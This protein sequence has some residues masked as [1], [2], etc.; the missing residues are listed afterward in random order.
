MEETRTA[1]VDFLESRFNQ[2]PA[3]V[4]AALDTITDLERLKKLRREVFKANTLQEALGII[5]QAADGTGEH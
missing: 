2:Q 4:D 3:G 5:A 1:I